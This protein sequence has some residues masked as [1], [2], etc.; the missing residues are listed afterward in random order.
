MNHALFC[1]TNAVTYMLDVEFLRRQQEM[2]YA[3]P[4]RCVSMTQTLNGR[5]SMHALNSGHTMLPHQQGER[6]LR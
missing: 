1:T 5:C 6:H 2:K 3:G 4:H